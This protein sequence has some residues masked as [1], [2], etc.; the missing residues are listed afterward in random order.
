MLISVLAWEMR[1]IEFSVQNKDKR[2]SQEADCKKLIEKAN[3]IRV[4]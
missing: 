2:K 1:E 3:R 4:L